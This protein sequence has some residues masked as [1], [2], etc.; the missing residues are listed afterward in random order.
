[1]EENGEYKTFAITYLLENAWN[2]EL[3]VFWD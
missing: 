1:M 3:K 2:K